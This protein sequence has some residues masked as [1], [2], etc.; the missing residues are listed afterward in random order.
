MALTLA[1][2]LTVR[3]IS[4]GRQHVQVQLL[5]GH[6]QRGGGGGDKCGDGGGR[7][8]GRGA[9]RADGEGGREGGMEMRVNSERGYGQGREHLNNGQRKQG[10]VWKQ[11]WGT[12]EAGVC[13]RHSDLWQVQLPSLSHLF[14]GGGQAARGKS[15]ETIEGLRY[16]CASVG[17]E[18]LTHPAG[19]PAHTDR[20]SH[21]PCNPPAHQHAAAHL[22]CNPQ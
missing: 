9:A 15:G 8:G 11:P 19:S 18:E 12:V 4:R 21:P 5:R 20:P 13:T 1:R 17:G 16:L 7:G 22:P 3:G 6:L 10:K 2:T 14:Q